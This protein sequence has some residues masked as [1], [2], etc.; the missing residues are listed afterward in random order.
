M[1]I[2]TPVSFKGKERTIRNNF[3]GYSPF[4]SFQTNIWKGVVFFGYDMFNFGKVTRHAVKEKHTASK[5]FNYIAVSIDY[6]SNRNYEFLLPKSKEKVT[7]DSSAFS[8]LV[9]LVTIEGE[10]QRLQRENIDYHDVRKNEYLDFLANLRVDIT[11]ELFHV[12]VLMTESEN[13]FSEQF[14]KVY[15]EFKGIEYNFS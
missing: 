13:A 10:L 3:M 7:L 15:Q 8:L 6:D 2:T 12:E 1:L 14:K 4:F 5:G 11:D 9:N